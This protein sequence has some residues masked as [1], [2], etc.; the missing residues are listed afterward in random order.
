[1]RI[2]LDENFPLALH[3]ALR[4]AGHTSEHIVELGLRGTSDAQILRRLALEELLFLTQD[5]DFLELPP[6]LK[7]IVLVSRVP[8]DLP[9]RIRVGIWLRAVQ[10]YLREKPAGRLFELDAQGRL[11]PWQIARG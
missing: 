1:V 6:G 11:H 8:Q 10:S 5:G 4:E 9:T 3:T 2:L 7:S